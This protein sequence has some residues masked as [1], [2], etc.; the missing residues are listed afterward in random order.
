MFSEKSDKV[1]KYVGGLPD[2]IQGCVMASKQKAMQ[3]AIEFSMK[4]MDQKIRS[5]ADRQAKNKRKLNDNLRNNQNQQHP[6][7]R[8]NVATNYT[9]GPEEKKVYEGS[10]PLCPKYNYHHNGKCA[11]KCTNCKR[12]GHLAWDFSSPAAVANNQ[13]AP[14]SFVSTVFSSLIDIIP[15]TL[16]HGYDVELADDK[17]I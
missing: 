7:R 8:Q 14:G 11:P 2:M 3:N 10:K 17:I 9:A 13:R 12:N 1:K 4:L 16:D 15:T 6:F 5:F